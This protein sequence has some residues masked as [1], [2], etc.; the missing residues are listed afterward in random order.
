MRDIETGKK[1]YTYITILILLI[2]S[3]P[4]ILGYLLLILSSFSTHMITNLDFTSFSFTL[5]NWIMIFQG[6]LSTLGGIKNDISSIILNTCIV[7]LG[8]SIVVTFVSTLSA[9]SLSRMD[10][11]GRKELMILLLLLHAFP[12]VALIIGVYLL[13]FLT[14]PKSYDLIRVY[15]FI[16]VIL[17]RAALEIPM[18]VWIMKG[19]FDNIPWELEWAGVI[20]G[21]SRIKIWWKIML[22]LVKPGILAVSLFAFLAGWEDIIY[23][24]TFLFDQTL[25]TFIESNI[26]V[27]FSQMPLIAAV[28]TL[29]L[30]PT[31][32]FFIIAQKLLLK[33]YSGG[34]KG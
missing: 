32:V 4:I 25:A 23:V 1:K 10:F 28:G 3:F 8:V 11:K 16:Y 13:Y 7:A 27:E 12:G 2:L 34:V 18:S 14:L 21:A 6:N 22:P 26:N 9:Y 19:F 20:D 15:S 29:Y 33:S 31:I 5:K 17:A 24:R 30:L